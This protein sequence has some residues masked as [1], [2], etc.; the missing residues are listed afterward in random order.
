MSWEPQATVTINGVDYSGKTLNGLS[1]TFGRTTIWEQ[2]RAG[3]ANVEIINLNDTAEPFALNHSIVIKVKNASNAD[4][5]IFTGVINDISVNSI[6]SSTT[7]K[8][9]LHRIR[10]IAPFALMARSIIGGTSWPKEYD[11]VRL[12]RIFTDAG[13]IIDVV[14]TPG[15]Y[16]FTDHSSALGD[17]Y[18]YAAKYASM[19]FGY[20]YETTDGKVGYANESRRLNDVDDNGYFSIPKSAILTSGITSQISLVDVAN[21]ISLEYKANAIK[22][23]SSAA[24]IAAYGIRGFDIITELEQ[25]SEAQNQVDRY[26]ALRAFPRVSLSNFNVQL[27]ITSLTTSEL[28]GLIAVYMGKPVQIVGL[29]NSIYPGTY[30]GFVEGWT[31]TINRLQATLNLTTSEAALSL[32]PTRWQDVSASLA[33]NGLSASLQWSDYE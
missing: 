4:V 21:D 26:L 6:Y 16:E 15:V 32:V 14:D 3:F 25:G 12:D 1:V 29:P 33:W 2:A 18:S 23:G 24:S 31:V 28:N 13:V 7:N 27:D 30:Q 8:V 5:T 9:A 17:A 10:A 20:I 22:T 19:A 11:D